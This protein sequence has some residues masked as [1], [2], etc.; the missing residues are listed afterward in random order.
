MKSPQDYV[1]ELNLDE[2][3]VEDIEE[4]IGT[5][6]EAWGSVVGIDKISL[7]R[8]V[9]DMCYWIVFFLRFS[10]SLIFCNVV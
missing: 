2:D 10:C 1:K 6:D 7:E 9:C 5:V 4:E 8:L 3:Q